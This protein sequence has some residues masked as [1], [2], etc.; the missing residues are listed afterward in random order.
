MKKMRE[1]IKQFFVIYEPAEYIFPVV[2]AIVGAV[3]THF[4]LKA[5]GV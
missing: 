1:K 2:S 3:I 4:V 5:L